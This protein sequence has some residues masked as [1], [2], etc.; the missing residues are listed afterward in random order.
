MSYSPGYADLTAVVLAGGSGMRMGAWRAPKCLYPINGVPILTRLLNHLAEQGLGGRRAVVCVGYQAKAVGR[1]VGPGTLVSDAG[2]GV[3]MCM[4]IIRAVSDYG[5]YR[6]P[7]LVCYGDELADVDIAA[8]WNFHREG[9]YAATVTAHARAVPFG[10]V[11]H[12][13]GK[14]AGIEEAQTLPANIGFAIVA[15][16]A[17]RRMIPHQEFSAYINEL[18][19]GGLPVGGY[20]HEGRQATVNSLTD[21]ETAERIWV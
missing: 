3:P 21:V 11:R 17:A 4:R 1:A 9:G 7:L 13:A 14:F 15:P 19:V 6:N 8:L 10:V 5:L 18:V 2:E 12:A 16:N 20:L